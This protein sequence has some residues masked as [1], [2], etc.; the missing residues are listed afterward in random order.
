MLSCELIAQ[1][2]FDHLKDMEEHLPYRPLF[3]FVMALCRMIFLLDF[4]FVF[5]GHAG[6]R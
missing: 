6:H 3:I 2:W 5:Q 4:Y 1:C